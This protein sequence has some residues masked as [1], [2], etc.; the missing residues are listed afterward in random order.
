MLLDERGLQSV[1]ARR[2]EKADDEAHE[3]EVQRG[4]GV[5]EATLALDQVG[6]GAKRA[7]KVVGVQGTGARRGGE[8]ADHASGDWEHPAVA[9]G[10]EGRS[11]SGA[12]G[13]ASRARKAAGGGEGESAGRQCGERSARLKRR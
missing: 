1:G 11:T 12:G 4:R 8:T 6:G 7:L 9:R 2:E 3:T 10:R 5:D 13:E